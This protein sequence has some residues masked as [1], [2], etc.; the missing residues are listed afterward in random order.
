M[1]HASSTELLTLHAVRLLGFAPTGPV[2]AR[3]G[4]DPDDVA[5]R[6]AEAHDAGLVSWSEFVDLSGWALTVAGRAE[7]ERLLAA[8]LDT[9]GARDVVVRAHEAFLP[10]NAVVT[11]VLTAVQLAPSAVLDEVGHDRL[12]SVGRDWRPVE[13]SLAAAL[14]R[15]GGYHARFLTAVFRSDDDP[16]WLAGTDVDSCHRVW[17]EL[18]EDLVATLG[19]TR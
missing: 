16:R 15:F 7:D 19:L 6:L 5:R 10:L 14:P 2:A 3:F 17:F 11:E 18:H 9:V 8:E 1:S 13:E 4:L 12:A